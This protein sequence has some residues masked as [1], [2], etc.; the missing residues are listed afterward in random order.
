MRRFPA[1]AP[2][3]LIHRV[4]IPH[5]RFERR[6]RLPATRLKLRRSELAS[7]CLT[8]VLSKEV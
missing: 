8:L 2:E 4:E 6:I 1:L 7:G 5:G 3:A